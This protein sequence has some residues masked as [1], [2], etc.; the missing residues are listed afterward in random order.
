[1]L[2]HRVHDG[3][4][5]RKS[6]Q[7]L[8][9]RPQSDELDI[10][11]SLGRSP[12]HGGASFWA[13]RGACLLYYD[14]RGGGIGKRFGIGPLVGRIFQSGLPTERGTAMWQSWKIGSAFGIPIKVHWSF[15]LLPVWI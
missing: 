14:F 5:I 6:F 7:G 1:M 4:D 2:A 12:F 8:F 15:L 11:A 13:F 10:A 3:A 9:M